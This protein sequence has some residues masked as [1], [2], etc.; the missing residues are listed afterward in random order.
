MFLINYK[1][2]TVINNNPNTGKFELYSD[3][4]GVCKKLFFSQ[5]GQQKYIND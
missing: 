1:N 3:S 4:E 5:R 2:I